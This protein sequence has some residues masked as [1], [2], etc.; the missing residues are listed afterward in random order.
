MTVVLN[1]TTVPQDFAAGTYS[2]AA[3]TINAGKWR[4]VLTPTASSA[5]YT[6]GNFHAILGQPHGGLWFNDAN[7]ELYTAP[8]DNVA[9]SF[10]LTW[11]AGQPI[12]LVLDASPGTLTA[13]VTGATTGNGTQSLSFPG[14]FLDP[15]L[16]LEVGRQNGGTNFEFLGNVSAIDDGVSGDSVTPAAIV[17]VGGSI[18]EKLGLK[19]VVSPATLTV[20]GGSISEG[21][22]SNSDG[23][24][25]AAIALVGGSV[26]VKRSYADFMSSALVTITGGSVPEGQGGLISLGETAV[27][28]QRFSFANRSSSVTVDTPTTGAVVLLCAGGKSSDVSTPWTDNLNATSPVVV[29]ALVEYPDFVGYGTIIA[30][31][32]APMTGGTGQAFTQPVTTGDENTTFA[33]AATV[34]GGHPRVTEVHNNVANASGTTQQTTPT[35]SIDG[36][37]LLVAYWWGSSPVVPPFSTPSPGVGAPFTAVPNGGFTVAESYL[38]NN[39]FGEV[40]AA[41]AYLYVPAGAGPS[42]RSVTWTHSPAQGAQLRLVAIQPALSE[43]A[44]PALI[45]LAGQPIGE[46]VTHRV[47]IAPASLL[48]SGGTIVEGIERMDTVV[49]AAVTLVG[50]NVL[51]RVARAVSVTSAALTIAGGNVQDQASSHHTDSITPAQVALVGLFVGTRSRVADVVTSASVAIIGGVVQDRRGL[52]VNVVPASIGV[53]ASSVQTRLGVIDALTPAAIVALGGVVLARAG[54]KSSVSPATVALLGGDVQD[55]VTSG[56]QD[57]VSPAALSI[58][59]TTVLTRVARAVSVVPA[60][61]LLQGFEVQTQVSESDSGVTPPMP[62]GRATGRLQ[63]R[64]VVPSIESRESEQGHLFGVVRSKNDV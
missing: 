15:T 18:D 8:D 2:A 49:P 26:P 19:D 3:S 60:L 9:M 62:P 63:G 55:L 53:S 17:I 44:T 28:F 64:V 56:A 32:P 1:I 36:E 11:S 59:G 23:V 13:T 27:D 4:V 54:R 12:T 57:V 29:G 10:A 31:T 34:A 48:I 35:I 24:A 46:R 16:L 47:A 61:V 5:T 38:V 14:P 7:L 45:T 22:G 40:Q 41:M 30:V 20:S 39:E 42:T 50:G 6:G 21:R 43:A 51:D 37:A 52:V 25:P 58:V 33:L